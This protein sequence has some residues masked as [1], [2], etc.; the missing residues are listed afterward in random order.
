[1]NKYMMSAAALA[2]CF[3][4]TAA[5]A[6]SDSQKTTT[7]MSSPASSSSATTNSQNATAN[8]NPSTADKATARVENEVDQAAGHKEPVT[9]AELRH[10]ERLSSIDDPQQALA[11]AELKNRQGEPLGSVKL[12]DMDSNGHPRTIH[13]DVGG[14]LGIDE[15]VVSIPASNFVYLKSRNLLVT[16][17]SKAEIQALPVDNM[18]K[19]TGS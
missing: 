1:M 13:A 5:F 10:A 4:S 8:P 12:I 18:N 14:F 15:H 11:T 19:P 2:V 9:R 16:R 7:T 17:M 3:G 6:Q